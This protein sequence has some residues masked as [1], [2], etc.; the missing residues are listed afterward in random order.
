ML[1]AVYKHTIDR[2]VDWSIAI[3]PSPMT[4]DRP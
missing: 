3:P 1:Y 4:A 2:W